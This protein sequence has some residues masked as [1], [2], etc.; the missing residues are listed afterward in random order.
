[1]LAERSD[2]LLNALEL[3]EAYSLKLIVQGAAEAHL[4]AD[5]LAQAEARVVLGQTVQSGLRRNDAYRR[6]ARYPAATL[7]AAGVQWTVGSGARSE[8]ATRFMALSAQ[9][10]VPV[11]RAAHP[12]EIVTADAADL[13]GVADKTGRLRPGLLADFVVWSG[14]PL[15]PASQVAKVYVDGILAYEATD[16]A[17]PGE[18]SK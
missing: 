6:A 11:D 9:L 10:A 16:Q 5:E 3:A 1:M 13:L 2:D 14:D 7:E 8:L 18:A 17:E 4:L 12:L 15:D